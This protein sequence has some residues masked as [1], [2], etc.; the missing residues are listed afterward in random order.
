MLHKHTSWRYAQLFFARGVAK[1][2]EMQGIERSGMLAQTDGLQS[3]RS[4]VYGRV[5]K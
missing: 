5:G 2:D 1:L 4:L 3:V